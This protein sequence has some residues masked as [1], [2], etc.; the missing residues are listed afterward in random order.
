LKFYFKNRIEAKFQNWGVY[1]YPSTKTM[2]TITHKLNKSL[3]FE[4]KSTLISKIHS[5]VK[6]EVMPIGK[7]PRKRFIII[8]G[9]LKSHKRYSIKEIAEKVNEQ[10]DMDGFA[11]VSERM[12]Y[13]DIQMMQSEFPVSIIKKDNKYQYETRDESITN[14]IL[15]QK[16]REIIEMALQTFSIYKG[17]GLFEKFDDVITRLMAGSVLRR[18]NKSDHK[19]YIQI[20]ELTGKTGQE[21]IEVI[22]DAIV[23]YKKLK[24]HYKPYGGES[25][26]R[27]ISPYLLKEF[28]NVWFMVAFADEFK[29]K[30]GTNIFK[31][32]RIQKI[33]P[34][35]E[36]YVIDDK[37]N[38][39]DYFKY[40]LG[41][42]HIHGAE[43][44]EVKLKFNRHLIPLISETKIHSSMEI[45]SKTEDEM[46]VTFTVYNTIELKNKILSYGANAEVI[47]PKELRNEIKEIII[48]TSKIYC[49]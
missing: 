45:I 30:N 29:Q 5:F 20:G 13:N 10:L 48:N 39:E 44:I 28:R 3:V 9:I 2:A 26:I 7:N 33:E 43:P 8:D 41:V 22:Y 18:L 46:E 4:T 23:N 36:T 21:W 27:T 31:L 35:D 49:K 6:I 16:D 32:T 25:K 19:K 17:S 14:E 37:F 11:M 1:L 34:C 40:S 12:I 47:S 15:D 42:F 24:I 38:P